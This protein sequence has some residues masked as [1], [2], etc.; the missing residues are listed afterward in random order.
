MQSLNP[1]G[2]EVSGE[3][4]QV[5][6]VFI[7]LNPEIKFLVRTTSSTLKE[8]DVTRLPVQGSYYHGELKPSLISGERLKTRCQGNYVVHLAMS[9]R[10]VQVEVIVGN[11]R[12]TSKP[13][14]I[15]DFNGQSFSLVQLD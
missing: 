14:S 12:L 5:G 4:A 11:T 10:Q 13:L 6:V 3:I 2:F 15:K 1:C 9:A 7:N 8:K